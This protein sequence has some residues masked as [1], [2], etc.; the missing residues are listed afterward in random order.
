MFACF[1]QP[2]LKATIT[3]T[4]LRPRTGRSSPTARRT[5]RRRSGPARCTTPSRRPCGSRPTSSRS[6]RALRE[7]DRRVRRRARDDPAGH[8]LPR[9]PRRAHGRRP[10]VHRDQAGLRLLPPQLRRAL[11][12]RQVRP[13][14]RPRV[15][16]RRDGERRRRDLP[17][18][19]RLPQPRHALPL[20]AP[21]RDRAARDGAHVVRRPRDDALVGR[22]VAQRVVRD[23]GQRREPV[24]GHRVPQ[25]L[26][27]VR[28]R[29]E[30]LGLP[31][32]T[33]CPRRTRSPRTSPTC[34][35][36]RSTSTASPTP[37]AR[38]CSSSWSPTSGRTSSSPGCG[39]TSPG[40]P[41]ATRR[42]TTCSAR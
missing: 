20:R 33:S 34:R 18:G 13:A 32:R 3:L 5:R 7:V 14:L 37:R 42:S 1:D 11:P 28:E 12:L 16:R 4:A 22:P 6:S 23:L 31:R 25:R 35:P 2:D 19:L 21:R 17:R 29:R 38:R 15:Q 36:S 40:T 30:V 26:D 10:A 41:T 8:L 27:D 39:S 9:E 24:R